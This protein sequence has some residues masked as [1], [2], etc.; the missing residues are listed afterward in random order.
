MLIFCYNK[1]EIKRNE[2]GKGHIKRKQNTTEQHF[3]N[4]SATHESVDP[5]STS[6]IGWRDGRWRMGLR[7]AGT[8]NTAHRHSHAG[9]FQKTIVDVPSLPFF[10]SHHHS[11]SNTS[12]HHP[13]TATPNCRHIHIRHCNRNRRNQVSML[14]V[15]VYTTLF[16]KSIVLG[17]QPAR[18]A[19]FWNFWENNC[20]VLCKPIYRWMAGWLSSIAIQR[21]IVLHNSE[22]PFSA[23]FVKAFLNA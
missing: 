11:K 9:S 14:R 8:R 17:G 2:K 19:G 3:L 21:Y 22:Q 15:Y 7:G 6:Y 10:T 13:P 5:W 20:S 1:Q 16:L 23:H 18:Y 12:T 4:R